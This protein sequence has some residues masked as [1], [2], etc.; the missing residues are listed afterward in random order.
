MMLRSIAT[1][2]T[3]FLVALLMVQVDVTY[4]GRGIST[5]HVHAMLQD[6]E[7]KTGGRL[8]VFAINTANDHVIEYRA[9]QRFPFQ[10]TAKVVGVAVILHKSMSDKT[11]LQERIHYSKDDLVA[12]SPITEL[13]L[14][15]GM[16]ISEL[17][18]ATIMYSDNTAMNLIVRRLGG[19]QAVTDFARA[20]GDTSFLLEHWEPQFNS[21]PASLSDTSTPEQ[22]AR[23]FQSYVLGSVLAKPQR[24]LLQ[25]W[26]KKNTTGD[27]RIRSGVPRGW[28]VGDKTGTSRSY[29]VTND[30]AVIWPP[31][32][33]PIILAIYFMSLN[34]E[35]NN[36]YDRVIA[37]V[38]KLVFT[39]TLEWLD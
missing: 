25:D 11:L 24:A 26:L 36:Q 34:A 31:A 33:K 6:L 23:S 16:T 3:M 10:S 7:T 29:G 20:T 19:V 38:A 30:I 9:R 17:C 21:N 4:A 28:I 5:K 32:G 27:A 18:A 22:M 14:K 37:D 13:H 39:K 12:W 15:D 8:G 1:K 35:D 2:S